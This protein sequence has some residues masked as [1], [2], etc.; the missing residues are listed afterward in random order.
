[1]R[2]VGCDWL[3]VSDVAR[4]A[5]EGLWNFLEGRKWKQKAQYMESPVGLG[6]LTE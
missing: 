3:I 1:M 2:K 4:V 6:Y 5:A